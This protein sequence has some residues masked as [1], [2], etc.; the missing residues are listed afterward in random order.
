MKKK[1]KAV[2]ERARHCLTITVVSQVNT[3]DRDRGR[4]APNSGSLQGQKLTLV[5]SEWENT[6]DTELHDI[7]QYHKG[8]LKK[9]FK[10]GLCPSGYFS[11]ERNEMF[12]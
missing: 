6:D 3:L 7:L 5:L 2:Q 4:T 11:T 8:A 9:K 1:K 12:R 10:S